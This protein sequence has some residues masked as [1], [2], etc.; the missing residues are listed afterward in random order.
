MMPTVTDFIQSNW[1]RSRSSRF[2][3]SAS[4]LLVGTG[5]AQAIPVALSPVLTRI[6][7]PGD[8]GGFVLFS[9]IAVIAGISA[10]GRY[11]HA[12]LLPKSRSQAL[13]VVLLTVALSA[14]VAVVLGIVVA[15]SRIAGLEFSKTT[16]WAFVP[17]YVALF[18]PVQAL[19]YLANRYHQFRSIARARLTAAGT[20]GALQVGLGLLGAHEIGLIIGNIVGQGAS[21]SFLLRRLRARLPRVRVKELWI[22]A[23]R[24]SN[25]PLYSLPADLI[26]TF[27]NQL[28][29]FILTARYGI[30]VGGFFGLTQRVLG[31]PVGLL[32]GSIADVF[33]N[34][35]A[36]DF[37]KHGNC[38]RVYLKTLAVLFSASIVP[39]AFFAVVAPW[40]FAKIFGERWTEAG[41]YARILSI[42]FFFRFTASPLG[43]VMYVAEKQKY[44][45]VWQVALFIVIFLSLTFGNPVDARTCLIRYAVSYSV[46]YLFYCLLSYK[47][48]CGWNDDNR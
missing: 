16:A 48:A 35:A 36:A 33:K 45:L 42:F 13:S 41:F 22:Q 10:T 27:A 38:R 29:L 37:K 44:D 6:Y 9:S 4:V 3:R 8:F 20:A 12:V 14:T 23:K 39:F 5:A 19:T 25:F 2:V 43:Y 34:A 15:I 32:A 7:S 1:K 26:N 24:F 21:V 30:E 17:F 31:L 46:M 11:E 28:P 47:C 40:L 18:G